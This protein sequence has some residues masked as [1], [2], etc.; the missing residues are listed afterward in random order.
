MSEDLVV[1]PGGARAR[2]LVHLVESGTILDGSAGRYRKL[3][4][5][6]RVLA[7]LG[8][9]TYRTVGRPLMPRH[10]V[11]PRGVAPAFGSGWITYASWTNATGTSIS[12]FSTQWVVPQAPATQSGQLIYIFNGIQNSTMIYQPVLQ[13]GDNNAFGGNYWCVA[14]WYADGQG[15]QAF[16]STPVNVNPGDTLVGIM[17]QTAQGPSGFS[18]NCQFQGIANSGLPI[19]NVEELTYCVETLECYSITQCSDYP[20]A[21]K[22]AMSAINIE[23]GATHPTLG[24]TVTNAVTD[25][26]QHTQ[27]FD[28][29]CASNGEVDLWY[30][31]SPYWTAGF[32]T[33]APGEAQEWWFSWGGTGDVGPQLIQAEPLNESGELATTLIAESLDNN[34]HVTYHALVRNNG[35]ATVNFQWRGGGR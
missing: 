6:G 25:C 23:T 32:G 10:V 13:W 22:T 7:D 5:S 28:L 24:W 29:D 31:S 33:I 3:H 15:G 27:L 12:Q 1:T 4:S 20:N 16:H 18:Y 8:P 11:Q 26:G 14:S 17:M 9:I 34:G 2:S 19:Q 35:T 21:D 30:R